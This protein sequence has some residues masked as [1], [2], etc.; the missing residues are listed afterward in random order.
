MREKKQ[1]KNKL[2]KKIHTKRSKKRYKIKEEV[3]KIK[4]KVKN[5]NRKRK[6]ER[7]VVQTLTLTSMVHL[8]HGVLEDNV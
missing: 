6:N 4:R 1:C 7:W 3:V 8:V 2:N 5:E